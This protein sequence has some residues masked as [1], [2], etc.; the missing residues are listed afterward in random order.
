MSKISPWIEKKNA[1]NQEKKI[2]KDKIY[3]KIQVYSKIHFT[4][5]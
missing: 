4:E 1:K 5:Y 3:Y 2:I